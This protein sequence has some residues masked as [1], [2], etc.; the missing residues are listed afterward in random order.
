[1]LY[2]TKLTNYITVSGH[3]DLTKNFIHPEAL[4]FFLVISEEMQLL[5]SKLCVHG[6]SSIA[7][8]WHRYT[9]Y[10]LAIIYYV[11]NYIRITECSADNCMQLSMNV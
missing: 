7:M 6:N 8:L 1:M 9:V 10:R 2:L 11:R 4:S 3:I 5:Y